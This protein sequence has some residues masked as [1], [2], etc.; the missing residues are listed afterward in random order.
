VIRAGSTLASRLGIPRLV[1]GATSVALVLLGIAVAP[2]AGCGADAKDYFVIQYDAGSDADDGARSDAQA[3]LDPTLGGPC[4]ED[5]Q[6]DDLIP[7]TFD[8]C[9]QSLS[10]CRNT[11]DDTQCA[12]AEFCNGQEKCVLR[13]GCAPGPVVTCGDGNLCTIDRCVEATKSCERAPRDAD[14]DGDP[15]DHCELNRDCD[16]TDPTVSSQRAEIC[17]N[18]KDDNCNGA[19]DEQ[20]CA[21]GAN[22]DCATALAVTAPGTFLLNSTASKKDYTTSCT[23][24]NPAAS[25][26]IVLAI[27]VPAGAA[28]DVLVRAKTNAPLNEVAVALE[29]TCGQQ[30]S[31]INCASIQG[32]P[33]SR[34]IARSVAGG[35]TVYAI[36]TTQAESPVDV[37]VDWLA[38]STKP[39]NESCAAPQAVALDTPFT[40]S[41]VDPAKDLDSTCD[42][43]R[44]G[45]LTY[46]FNLA[47]PQDIRIFASTLS[48]TGQP[49]VSMRSSVCADELRCRFGNTP[50][51]ARNLPA[52]TH[53]FS[54]AGSTQIDANVVVK[55][56]PPTPT[57]PNQT[58]ATAPPLTPNVPLIVNLGGQE[59]AI[60]NGCLAG[61]PNAAYALDLAAPS[62]VLVIGRFPQNDIGSVSINLP[63]CGTADLLKCSL[64]GTPQ[65]A[66]YRNL[67]AGSYRTVIA[68]EKGYSTELTALVRPTVPPTP[69][70]SDDCVNPQTIPETGGFFTGDTTNAAANF[71]AGCDSPGQPIG[72]AKDQ[73]LRLVLTQKRRVVLDMSGSVNTT[74][75]SVRQ[76]EPCPGV[77]V[78]NACNPGLSANRS[79]LDL[80]LDPGTYWVQI[81]GYGGAVGQWNLDVRVLAP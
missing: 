20:P 8:R 76:G 42:A 10:R 50:V 56:Y 72:G 71:S 40:V 80:T 41:L 63:A 38:A 30:A 43:A 28:K 78:P 59:D 24:Q 11:P 22:D 32:S 39:T 31:E 53:V 65:R 52:G 58:C 66:S 4:T 62:D 48:G 49:V 81:D 13:K 70:T 55:T 68:D 47:A 15:D 35:T 17:G 79:F 7:C 67:G 12:D 61:G 1:G 14:G 6:C 9:D 44:T 57:P 33:D 21:V 36:I 64:G 51:F 37:T 77:E 5:V 19:V 45:E 75:L 3:E 54:V 60:K 69:V 74:L 16:D 46:S 27:T 18:F 73:I 25:R 2:T 26:D 23:V 34:T 29:A